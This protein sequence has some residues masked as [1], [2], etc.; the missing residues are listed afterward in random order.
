MVTE[1][2]AVSKPPLK[3]VSFLQSGS[4]HVGLRH[5]EVSE[6][7]GALEPNF[8]AADLGIEVGAAAVHCAHAAL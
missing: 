1:A 6:G 3:T 4:C 2:W 5:S 8:L 7:A